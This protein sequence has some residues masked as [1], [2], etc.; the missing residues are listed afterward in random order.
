MPATAMPVTPSVQSALVAAAQRLSAGQ[1]DIYNTIIKT[2]VVEL[3]RIGELY[4]TNEHGNPDPHEA[5]MLVGFAFSNEVVTGL[6]WQDGELC[7]RG[8]WHGNDYHCT[9]DLEGRRHD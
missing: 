2:T 7:Q 1:P 6:R 9:T 8:C 5:W 4:P 3:A